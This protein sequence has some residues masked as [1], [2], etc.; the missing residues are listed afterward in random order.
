MSSNKELFK[1]LDSI[2]KSLDISETQHKL[3]EERYKAIGRWLAEGEYCISSTG[4]KQCF[5]DGEIYPHGS[6]KLGTAVKPTGTDEFDID[7]VFYTPNIS[8]DNLSPELLKDLIGDRLKE[9]NTYKN[10]LSETNRGWCV[11]YAN[12]FHLDITPS[13]DNHYE[14]HND[15]ELV[16]DTKLQQYMPSNPRGYAEWFEKISNIIPTVTITKSMFES[17]NSIL[18]FDDSATVTEIPEHNMNK[19]L[20][21]RF[22]QIFK[23]H[24]DV[25][26]EGK[27]DAP[28]SIIITTL[29][30]KS[31]LYCIEQFSYDNEYDLMVDVLKN[32]PKF[33]TKPL[34]IYT[35][36]NPT[37]TGENFAE[38]WDAKPKKRVAF[39][40][41]HEKCQLFFEK[42]HQNMGQHVLFDSLKEG[43]GSK[44]TEFVREQYI[45]KINKDRLFGTVFASSVGTSSVKANTFYGI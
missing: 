9:H 38:K 22:I 29:V 3:A 40:L 14:P 34:G 20:L 18:D 36:E 6:I 41:W 17:R 44:P 8:A 7:L 35:I 37:V 28:I 19:P 10:M 43:F 24:R 39:Y 45:N 32:I 30:T 25:M 4:K 13:L 33:I 2:G 1:I 5:K 15:S 23:R 42:F 16:A 31:Y 21:K 11:N 27:D 26:F 12:E